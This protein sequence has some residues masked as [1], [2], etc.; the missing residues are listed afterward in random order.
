[1]RSYDISSL[2]YVSPNKYNMIKTVEVTFLEYKPIIF[3]AVHTLIQI[4]VM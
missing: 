2:T 1:M 4:F 3:K